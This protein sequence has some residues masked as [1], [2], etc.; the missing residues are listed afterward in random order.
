M[1]DE[2]KRARQAP[3][4]HR[5]SLVKRSLSISGHRTSVS[6]EDAFWR[7]LKIVAADRAQSLS[8]V[9]AEIDAGRGEANLSS[10]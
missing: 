5:S 2:A 9:V 4:R 10:A 8:Q 7:Q 1:T 3:A 6:L